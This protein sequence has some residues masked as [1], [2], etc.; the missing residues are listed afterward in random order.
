[1]FSKTR[2]ENPL[3]HCHHHASAGPYR[4][5]VDLSPLTRLT[6]FCQREC[7]VSGL[8][9]GFIFLLCSSLVFF[10]LF[11]FANL[12]CPVILMFYYRSS[13]MH[14]NFESNKSNHYNKQTL[15]NCLRARFLALLYNGQGAVHPLVLVS[16]VHVTKTLHEAHNQSLSFWV[17]EKIEK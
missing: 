3:H 10:S 4:L 6:C 7:A 13:W 1:M 16:G 15:K 14:W 12:C 11:F 9:T 17:M 8:Y 5:Q 2:G